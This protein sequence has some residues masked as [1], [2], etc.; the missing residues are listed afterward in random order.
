MFHRDL[1]LRPIAE[2]LEREVR[3]VLAL[4]F[5]EQLQLTNQFELH[6]LLLVFESVRYECAHI[7]FD[8]SAGR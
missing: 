8:L 6:H 3:S 5:L 4:E 2:I 1:E 7:A